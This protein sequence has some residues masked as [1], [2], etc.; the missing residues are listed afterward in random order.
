MC[1]FWA[2]PGISRITGNKKDV[3]RERD[4]P[5]EYHE[6]EK[7][8]L[9]KTQNG[10]FQECK[11]KY[12]EVKMCQR[13]F[14]NCKPFFVVPA[15]HADQN[16][17]CCRTPVETRM[18]FTACI[19]YRKQVLKEQPGKERDYPIYAHLSDLVDKTLCPKWKENI[20]M[21]KNVETESVRTVVRR[22]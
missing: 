2:S 15:R 22:C 14:E 20:F 1:D 21:P 7:Q 3:A 6:H 11:S 19:N 8:V 10:V 9:E 4:P 5:N 18:L 17:S 16:S 12:P 13:T